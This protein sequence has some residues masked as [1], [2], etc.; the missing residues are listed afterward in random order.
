[1]MGSIALVCAALTTAG[2]A[3]GRGIDVPARSI[4]PGALVHGNYDEDDDDEYDDAEQDRDRDSELRDRER[5]LRDRERELRDRDR[6]LRDQHRMFRDEHRLR[7]RFNDSEQRDDEGHP[8]TARAKASN[9]RVS[10][11]VNGPVT[12][13]LRV[14]SGEIEVAPADKPQIAATIS[15]TRLSG[16]LQLV[17]YGNR[18]ELRASGQSIKRGNV[19]VEVPWGT[20]VEVDSTS[21]DVTT[22]GV[23]GDVRVRTMSGDVKVQN[24]RKI[25]VETISGDVQVDATAKARLHT[26]SGNVVAATADPAAQI[27]FESA[28]GNLDWTGVCAKGCHLAVQTVSGDVKLNVD[29]KSSF[30]LA[31]SSHS[32]ELRDELK[33][34]MKRAP[35]RKHGEPGVWAEAMYGSGDGLIE[36]DAFSGDLQIRRK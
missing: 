2:N 18:V 4:A 27:E 23:G 20:N 11:P 24:A 32:G 34:Q 8:P 19:W 7:F 15:G 17:Q 25:D 6:A 10:L 28:S 13:R 21:G 1:M 31:Y 3:A 12:L 16:D 35:N 26:V 30:E 14:Q 5:E 33:L 9:G 36:C 22:R 29:P